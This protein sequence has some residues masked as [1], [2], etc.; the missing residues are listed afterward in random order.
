MIT[1]TIPNERFKLIVA[2]DGDEIRDIAFETENG[3][4]WTARD[5][6][7][8]IYQREEDGLWM[9]GWQEGAAGPF[10]SSQFAQAVADAMREGAEK[11]LLS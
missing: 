8:A 10:E 7:A 1:D 11:P 2:H 5:P 3:E 9:V 4:R 6:N